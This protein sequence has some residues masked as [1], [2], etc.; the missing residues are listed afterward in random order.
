VRQRLRPLLVLVALMLIA[1]ACGQKAGVGQQVVAEGGGGGAGTGGGPGGGGQDGARAARHEPGPNDKSGVTDTEIVVGVHAPVTGASPI[2]QRTFD[3]GKDIYWKF[4]ASKFP[5][6]LFG[7]TVRVVFRDDEF[8]PNR[9]VSVCREMVE[10][11]K[12]FVLVGGGGADQITACAKYADGIGVPYLSA[13]VNQEGLE[14]LSTYYATSLT[15]AQQAP[16]LV[17]LIKEKGFTKV[18]AVT[19]DTP[20]F[21]DAHEAFVQ[22]VKDADLDLVVDTPIN[23]TASSTEA[24]TVVQELKQKGAEV[25][26]ILVAPTVYVT[27]LATGARGQGYDPTWI[28]P[29]I[30]S[31]LNAVLTFGCP[32]VENGLFFSPFPGMDV[33]DQLDPDFRPAYQQFGGGTP[34]DD[35]GLALW[36]LNK[37]LALMFEKVGKDLGRAALMNAIETTPEFNNGVYPPIRIT[38]DDHLGGTGAHLLDADCATKQ[39]KT[40]ERFVEARE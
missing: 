20:S 9:A 25:V 23:K 10:Q 31:G 8:N 24:L 4:L 6:K 32:A 33:I 3:T 40:A 28:G 13:G 26:M 5:D 35:I 18:G 12:A 37:G 17:D 16:L 30:T 1:A 7:R 22:A 38:A 21:Q 14:G 2:P 29:G 11:E 19:A 39:Y 15:Y 27:G 34:P 36:G